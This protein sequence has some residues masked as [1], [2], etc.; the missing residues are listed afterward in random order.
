MS[1]QSSKLH[2]L[3]ELK[4]DRI[5]SDNKRSS[6]GKYQDVV[7]GNDSLWKLLQFEVIS[8]FGG[9]IPGA[10]GL[11]VRRILYRALFR[12]VGKG[13]VFGWNVTLR[14]PSNISIG[15]RAVIDDL[16][17]LS[18]RGN[19]SSINIGNGVLI[20]R[21]AQVKAREGTINIGSSSHMGPFSIIGTDQMISIGKHV[22]TGALCIIGLVNKS[23]DERDT[24]MAL[25]S[26]KQKG[27]VIIEDDVS[28]GGNVSVLDGVRIGMGSV[29][30][31]GAVVTKQ[32][33]PYAIAY[34]VPARVVGTR[35]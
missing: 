21:G 11:V 2:K 31:A 29:I 16:S 15:D 28:L 23:I 32:V 1:M 22:T 25:Q 6:F 3:Q 14:Q 10:L 33:P 26:S 5:L 34:G 9:L 35:E 20:G 8:S 17:M 19:G 4:V 24:P 18:S 13:V 30:G 7:L 12:S 27:G